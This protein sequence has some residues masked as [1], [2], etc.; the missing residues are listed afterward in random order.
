MYNGCNDGAVTEPDK[1]TEVPIFIQYPDI[2]RQAG[3]DSDF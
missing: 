2:V 3:A 1:A